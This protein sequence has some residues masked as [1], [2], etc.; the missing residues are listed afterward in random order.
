M[1]EPEKDPHAKE[2]EEENTYNSIDELLP[3]IRQENMRRLHNPMN[4]WDLPDKTVSTIIE[5]DM[6][7]HISEDTIQRNMSQDF[8]THGSRNSNFSQSSWRRKPSTSHQGSICEDTQSNVPLIPSSGDEWLDTPNSTLRKG[9]GTYDTILQKNPSASLIDTDSESDSDAIYEQVDE[10]CKKSSSYYGSVRPPQQDIYESVD[11]SPTKMGRCSTFLPPRN[12]KTFPPHKNMDAS[13]SN[14]DT[15]SQE[16]V[17]GI[18]DHLNEN[19]DMKSS[20][21]SQNTNDGHIYAHL[22]DNFG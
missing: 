21:F 4:K 10:L 11:D 13:L 20:R 22:G 7:D 15:N 6:Y 8:N 16:N 17:E 2:E 19:W 9:S 18:Y 14:C 3:K 5:E 1:I 12:E